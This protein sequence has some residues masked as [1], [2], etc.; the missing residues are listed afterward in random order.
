MGVGDDNP[1]Y[2]DEDYG[3]ATRWGSQI[4]HGTQMGHLKSPMY[5]DPIPEEIRQQTKSLFRGIHV[6]VSGGTWDW[7]RPLRPGDRI[8][9]FDGEESLDVKQ[10]EFA[11]KSVIQVSRNVMINQ[12]GEVL[13]VYRILRV[14]TERQKSRDKGKYADI[15]PAHYTD[16]DYER[17][18][19]IYASEAAA[20][21]RDAVLGGRRRRRRAPADG[22][23]P[24]DRHRDDRVPLRRLRLR[25]LRTARRRGSATRTASASSRS[26]SRTARACGTSPSGCTGTAN[27]PRRSATRWPTTTACSAS[28][29]STTTSSDW[30]G[31]DACIVR[32]EDSIRKFNYM[33]D[34]QFLTG[35]VTAKREEDGQHLV[36]LELHMTSQRDVET[37]YG[38]ATVALASRA[39]GLP[40]FP[41]VP[42]DL[43]RQA[44]TMFARHNE[45]ASAE[46]RRADAPIVRREPVPARRA[47]RRPAPR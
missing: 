6:F 8:F 20:R 3:R 36:D 27:G 38:S 34:T 18:D 2:I 47:R 12:H 19:E 24:D 30:A 35:T 33:G 25:A 39:N 45:L 17:I 10:S 21:Q 29:G 7:Y 26:T 41:A 46:R 1:L 16:A 13:G 40:M 28:A 37:A 22:E 5:G 44:S 31:D 4:G 43:R 32:M 11:G 15:E 14:L 42:D 23:G 9:S